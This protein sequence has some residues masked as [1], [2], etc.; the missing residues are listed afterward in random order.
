MAIAF[1][2]FYSRKSIPA[3]YKAFPSKIGSVRLFLDL[4][5]L[6]SEWSRGWDRSSIGGR[7]GIHRPDTMPEASAESHC[8]SL[9]ACSRKRSGKPHSSKA[10]RRKGRP[11]FPIGRTRRIFRIRRRFQGAHIERKRC[12]LCSVSRTWLKFSERTARKKHN[13]SH[14]KSRSLG[15]VS[16]LW[17]T[18]SP[19]A[20]VLIPI[21]HFRFSGNLASKIGHLPRICRPSRPDVNL[22][23]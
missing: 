20:P 14:A 5:R 10:R 19:A 16:G 11:R 6:P 8:F 12:G 18:T 2:L 22:K 4:S 13:G 7:P 9:P 17:R 21:R 1:G 15:S 3:S 23:C